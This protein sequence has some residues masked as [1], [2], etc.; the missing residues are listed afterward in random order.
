MPTLTLLARVCPICGSHS[1]SGAG[2]GE[3]ARARARELAPAR[4][5]LEALDDFAFASRKLPEYMHWQLAECPRCDLVYADL[6]PAPEELAALYR[7]ADF[8]SRLEAD[9][10]SRTYA[11][12]LPRIARSLP[13]TAGVL[14]V[15]TS[16][17]AFL[18]E[19][20]AAGFTDVAGV[21]PSF[22]PIA[23][24][25]P[26]IRPLIRHDIFR[27]DLFPSGSLR[28]I[29][30]FQTIEHLDDP[31]R[32]ARDAHRAL[33]PGGALFLIAHNRRAL[34][35][36]ILGKQS[37]IF[38]LEHLQLFSPKS[39]RQLFRASGFDRVE[40][41]PLFNRYPLRYWAR[42][43]PFPQRLKPRLLSFLQS[44]PIG[45]WAVALP[46]GNIAAIGY[47]PAQDAVR[48]GSIG[49]SARRGG[50]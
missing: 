34:S 14:D 50:R 29:T 9:F 49:A 24:A 36:R 41:R 31:L 28:L 17:G 44:H 37:P 33:K 13:D 46:A 2:Q 19:L 10:A 15:G 25:D 43:F 45:S 22:A 42:L 16:D 26:A 47:K 20:V 39:L 38:D 12:F 21:E 18:E 27:P 32:F 23:A 35:A 8:D 30:C 1:G 40:L 7:D 11:R 3:G 48:E 5:D 4:V 6:A